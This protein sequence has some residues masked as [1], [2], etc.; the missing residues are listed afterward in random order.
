MKRE[1]FILDTDDAR[2]VVY[3]DHPDFKTIENEMIDS[4]RWSLH[5]K[6]VVQRLSDSKYFSSAYSKGAT[7]MQD[8]RPY[9]NEHAVFTEVFP[10]EKT[11]TVYE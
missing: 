7:E 9:D 6:I 11:I 8:E 10:V 4:S 2:E 1:Q 5:Y 3:G